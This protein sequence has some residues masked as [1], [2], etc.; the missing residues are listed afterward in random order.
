RTNKSKRAINYYIEYQFPVIVNNRYGRINEV[1][2]VMKIASKRFES[3][4]E[5]N[6][7]KIESWR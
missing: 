6:L 2:E 5:F 4:N 7:L 1:T 3:N